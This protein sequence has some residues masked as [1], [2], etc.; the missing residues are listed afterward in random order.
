MNRIDT[1]I[2][3]AAG[4]GSRM[5]NITNGLPKEMLPVS[6]KLRVIDFAIQEAISIKPSN[7]I[8]VISKAKNIIKEYLDK[9]Y[10]NVENITYVYQDLPIGIG[11][12]ILKAE[13]YVNSFFAVILPDEIILGEKS[14]I[15]ILKS[16]YK[17]HNAPVIGIMRH[18]TPERYGVV[19]CKN[20]SDDVCIIKD[21]VE[22]PS[23]PPSND[24]IIGR[25]IL[26][27]DIFGYIKKLYGQKNVIELT[28]AI[29]YMLNSS[30]TYYGVRL[31]YLRFDCGNPDDYF[32]ALNKIPI[33]LG[34]SQW[35][36]NQK[37]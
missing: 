24:C 30:Y 8:I 7:I 1:V 3:P 6:R 15:S 23:R 5:R 33:Y 35:V 11:D 31:R 25:Y 34:V 32:V 20:V 27:Y 18:E 10:I 2:I 29:R 17:K 13:D 12:A 36:I 19:V 4:V 37:S 22:K 21:A 16:V 28:D 14:P 26:P 9:K